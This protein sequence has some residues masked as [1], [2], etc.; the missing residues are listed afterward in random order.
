MQVKEIKANLARAQGT[1]VVDFEGLCLFPEAQLP[2]R[3]KMPDIEKFDGTGNPT[4][5]VRLIINTLKPMGLSDELI[6]QLFQRTLKGG[7]LDW[8]LTLDFTKYKTWQ[9]IVNVFVNQFSYNIQ[10]EYT[11]RDLDMTKQ[12]PKESF[13]AFLIR[14][15]EK[16]AKVKSRPT[17]EEQVRTVVKNLQPHYF[18]YIYPQGVSDFKRLHVVGQQ[19]E[20]GFTMGHL[21]KSEP[22]PARKTF[23][24]RTSTNAV[25][26]INAITP[27]ATLQNTPQATTQNTP[28]RGF[29]QFTPLYMTLSQA[30][31]TL[32]RQGFLKPLETPPPQ[33]PYGPGYDPTKHCA[34]HQHPGHDTDRCRRL[35]HEIQDLIDHGTIQTPTKPNVQTNPLPNHNNVPPPATHCVNLSQ[36]STYDPSQYIVPVNQPK[37][38][39]V[40]PSDSL[41]A[42]IE[43]EESESEGSEVIDPETPNESEGEN[44]EEEKGVEPDIPFISDEEWLRQYH[45]KRKMEKLQETMEEFK[46]EFRAITHEMYNACM[47]TIDPLN[48]GRW[49]E[50]V[51][52]ALEVKP[53]NPWVED[54]EVDHL[55]R[56]GRH[57]K[58]DEL[59]GE[60]PYAPGSKPTVEKEFQP[61]VVHQ[62]TN[63]VQPMQEEDKVLKQL[64]KIQADVS[65]W[66][67]LMA[68]YEHQRAVLK[69]LGGIEVP[70][71]TPP[72]TL[73]NMVTP[74]RKPIIAFTDD[75]L[76]PEGPAHNRS[77]YISVKCFK[78]WVP[79]VLVDNGSAL[80]I[81]PHQ[82]ALK[83]GLTQDDYQSADLGVRGYDNSKREVLGK[84]KI[85]VEID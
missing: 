4:S 14:W 57:F 53:A 33:P 28:S 84:V 63:P 83:L 77:L 61:E 34:F 30:L 82:V 16:A 79:V 15:R 58:P 9:E 13:T 37:P 43:E 70:I 40:L 56:S 67:L 41:C 46:H 65:I 76:P 50:D 44:K 51:R 24:A 23:P 3:F 81:C 72:E 25:N 8:F 71:D 80:N 47:V 42:L 18:K 64:K 10:I 19:I 59:R 21:E 2:E 74:Y 45:A 85:V 78:N 52:E 36:S 6:A 73:V 11:S 60:K 27:Q 69:A 32:T 31:A 48:G 49:W 66:G 35:K 22:T 17:E 20:D 38:K 7:A 75:D 5:H 39:A 54:E 55:T 12:E 62:P 68:S 26:S 29:R 1:T